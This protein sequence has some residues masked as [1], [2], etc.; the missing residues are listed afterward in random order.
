[1]PTYDL[2]FNAFFTVN[3]YVLTY[4]VDDVVYQQDT[5]AFGD[6]ITPIAGPAKK[7]F[8]FNRWVGL[9]ET[10]PAED[11]T[12]TS[13]YI[14]STGVVSNGN[15]NLRIWTSDGSLFIHASVA[16]PYRIYDVRGILVAEGVAKDVTQISLPRQ[17]IYVIEINGQKAKFVVY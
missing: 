9:P 8:T 17:T 16:S 15:D 1:M 4:K 6:T 3:D 2:T 5:I 14:Q 12:V 10:M 11:I 13:L 7:G